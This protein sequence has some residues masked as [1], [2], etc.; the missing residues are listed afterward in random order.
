MLTDLAGL[1]QFVRKPNLVD[2]NNNNKL[3]FHSRGY[4]FHITS[5][6]CISDITL[7]FSAVPAGFTVF[8]GGDILL[9]VSKN[10]S[11]SQ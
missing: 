7:L 9:Q 5:D 4:H 11:L 6:I 8:I 1:V 3:V 2:I 10:S